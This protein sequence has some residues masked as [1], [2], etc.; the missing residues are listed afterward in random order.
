MN[1]L[2][3]NE[4]MLKTKADLE[5][6]N[7]EVSTIVNDMNTN[8]DSIVL[9]W[10]GKKAKVVLEPIER[11]KLKNTEILNKITAKADEIGKAYETYLK[12][13][14]TQIIQSATVVPIVETPSPTSTEQPTPLPTD[15]PI[16]TP[17]GTPQPTVAPIATPTIS[18]T[19]TPQSTVAPTAVPTI[20]PTGTPQPTVAPTLT[21]NNIK[22]MD[23]TG[24]YSR[25]I[26]YQGAS[27]NYFTMKDPKWSGWL[28]DRNSQGLKELSRNGTHP[29]ATINILANSGLIAGNQE[30]IVVDVLGVSGKQTLVDGKRV[31]DTTINLTTGSYNVGNGNKYKTI[32]SKA[33]I[34]ST[35]L[36]SLNSAITEVEK[37]NIVHCIAQEG[38][39]IAKYGH[40][41]NLVGVEKDKNGSVTGLYVLDSLGRTQSEYDSLSN[42]NRGDMVH[43]IQ[44]GLVRID[45]S[46]ENLDA[47]RL[48]SFRAID[49]GQSQTKT[50]FSYEDYLNQL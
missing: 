29:F 23:S 7:T 50:V 20:S 49:G 4:G 36:G 45:A 2:I 8:L 27:W 13:S 37:G 32:L 34:P 14:E 41:L 24:R 19:G 17:T 5:L 38:S 40:Y 9:N 6:V 16:A 35:D 25:V 26:N 21:S 30:D 3:V 47:V 18:P 1:G 12:S 22:D 31:G 33:G 28:L 11:I 39:S 43:V 15:A 44:P 10:T 46:K 48:A 42:K